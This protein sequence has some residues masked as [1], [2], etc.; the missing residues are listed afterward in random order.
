MKTI[1]IKYISQKLLL[2]LD[3]PVLFEVLFKEFGNIVI[4]FTQMN[5]G[6][7]AASSWKED[8]GF[9]LVHTRFLVFD[10]TERRKDLEDLAIHLGR[11]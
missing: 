11:K 4:C 5:D 3:L 7:K 10:G 8:L 2:T 9:T 6:E 1:H